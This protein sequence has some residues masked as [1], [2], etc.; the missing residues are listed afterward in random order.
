MDRAASNP[1][2]LTYLGALWNDW[3]TGMCGAV[4]VP[5]TA[6]AVLW[7]HA[8]SAKLL[9]GCL[10]V[11][12]F[13]IAGYRVWRNERSDRSKEVSKLRQEKDREIQE[14]TAQVTVLT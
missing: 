14:L 13:L 3:L 6:I 11:L 5:F 9:W 7:A 1:N 4:S 2:L 10:A 12:A 8:P